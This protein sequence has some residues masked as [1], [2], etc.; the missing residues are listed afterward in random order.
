M[1]ERKECKKG[2]YAI[3]FNALDLIS[4]PGAALFL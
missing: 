1:G 4:R 3:Q 2:H